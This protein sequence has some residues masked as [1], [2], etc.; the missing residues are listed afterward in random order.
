[1][2][3]ADGGRSIVRTR[4]GIDM[5][6]KSFPE[7]WLVVDIERKPGTDALRHLPYFNFV[8]DPK[9]PVVSCVQPT[10]FTASNSC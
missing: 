5:A 2:V 3:G 9:L 1:M 6:G 10:S 8:V 4:L 7:P